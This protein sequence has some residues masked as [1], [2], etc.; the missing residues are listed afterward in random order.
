MTPRRAGTA[1]PVDARPALALAAVLVV[2][3]ALHLVA[4]RAYDGLIPRRLGRPR[5]WVL[6]SGLAELACGA[7]VAVPRT[8]RRGGWASAALF[9]AVLPGNVTMAW[10][11]P[12][13]AGGLTPRTVVAW[14]RL[15]LQVP[16]VAWAARV[17]RAAA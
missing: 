6:A 15:P 13:G 17:A 4:P 12:R 2:A 14:A 10:R 8:R 11:A 9:V 7:A 3:G 5:P 1:P 16:L